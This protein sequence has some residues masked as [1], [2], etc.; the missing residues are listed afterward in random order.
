ME[1]GP[2]GTEDWRR[3]LKV[4]IAWA[5]AAKAVALSLLWALFFRGH[6]S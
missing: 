6:G 1:R 4:K 5:L 2:A 3:D